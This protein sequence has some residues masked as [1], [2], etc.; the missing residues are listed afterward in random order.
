M[1]GDLIV[2]EELNRVSFECKFYKSFDYHLLFK[3]NKQFEG[4][5]DQAIEGCNADQIWFLCIKA[6][7]RDP[8]I[9]FSN[10]YF[11]E[12]L[13]KQNYC[14]Y[15]YNGSTIYITDLKSFISLNKDSILN[16]T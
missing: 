9:A 6:N 7:R 4:W 15:L 13:S 14:S 1:T 12:N 10:V 2:P 11:L 16:F 8:I 5:V 3:Q